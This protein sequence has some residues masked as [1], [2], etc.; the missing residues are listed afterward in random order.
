[1]TTSAIPSLD[2]RPLRRCISSWMWLRRDQLTRIAIV[3]I[4]NMA[5]GLTLPYVSRVVFDQ[6]LPDASPQL[7]IAIACGVVF[8]GAHCAWAAW[9]RGALNIHLDVEIER[10]ALSRAVWAM[11]NSSASQR[12]DKNAG[13][14]MTTLAGAGDAV[15][16]CTGAFTA[17]LSQGTLC[18]GYCVS[19]ALYSAPAA[20]VV[21]LVNVC[22][23]SVGLILV[24]FES[25]FLQKL[26]ASSSAQQQLLHLLLS[27]LASLRGLFATEEAA[28]RWSEKLLVSTN[29]QRKRAE[30][31]VKLS[32]VEGVG[33][34]ALG[35]GLTIW[36]VFQCFSQRL[37]LGEMLFLTATAGGLSS[38][39]GGVIRTTLGLRAL[40]PY[41]SRVDDLVRG[42]T[43]AANLRRDR[44][45]QPAAP[46]LRDELG[47][48]GLWF[49][50][51]P[52]ERWLYENYSWS[53]ARGSVTLLQSPSG[54]GKSTLLRMLAGL[55]VPGKG[56]VTIFG[57]PAVA[58]RERVLYLPQSCELFE[59]SIRENLELLSS[60]SRAR[61]REVSRLTGLDGMLA[62][63][64][65]GEETLISAQGQNLSS[66]QRQMILLTA[67]FASD[68][69]VLLLD[70]STSQIDART[71]AAFRWDVL[72]SGR[73][74]VRVEHA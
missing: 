6:A 7:M 54:S 26:L 39:L 19:L 13:W 3:S 71:R 28:R 12:K 29:D 30:V 64:P 17:V 16:A 52:A 68:R 5:L 36:A 31:G 49:R 55:I 32:T 44:L 20:L 60:A 46:A 42:S 25:G 4:L 70:E 22:L 9:L 65:M 8:I 43:Q 11:V 23:A 18:L 72:T 51:G 62:G 56:K 35:T 40:G 57:V 33:L 37:T 47:I 10:E 61:I 50:Y 67:A 14:M 63:F 1:M 15:H 2:N 21:V 48:E 27:H 69:E 53:V 66:G 58:A 34:Q 24:R 45:A 59:T 74:V 41:A 38:A 73:T